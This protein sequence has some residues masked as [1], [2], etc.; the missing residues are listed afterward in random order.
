MTTKYSDLGLDYFAI[1]DILGAIG[2]I[3]MVSVAYMVV[4]YQC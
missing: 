4:I 1:K 3:W 2:E